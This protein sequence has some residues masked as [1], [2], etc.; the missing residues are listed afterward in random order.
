MLLDN[1]NTIDIIHINR[2]WASMS[3]SAATSL[4]RLKGDLFFAKVS[5]ATKYFPS[6]NVLVHL[7]LSNS[8]KCNHKW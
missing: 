3:Y 8:V 7:K 2:L 5:C 1:L 6:Q 4:N